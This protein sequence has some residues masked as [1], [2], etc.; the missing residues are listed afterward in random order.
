M[1][2]EVLIKKVQ[3]FSSKNS[4]KDDIHGFGH[5]RRVYKT[6]IEIGRKKD[7]NMLVLKISA[8]LHD[9]GRINENKDMQ[10]LNHATISAKRAVDFLNS[11]KNDLTQ[12]E[13]NNIF[14][15][16]KAHSFSN[17][18]FPETLEARILS[19]ADKIDALGAIGLYR[20]IGFTIKN[21]GNIKD[22]QEH[23]ENKIM[24]LKNRIFLDISKKIAEKKEKIIFNFY[25][26]IKKYQ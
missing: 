14:H 23:L 6:C 2:N 15:S 3:E 24:L 22:V 10:T 4:S 13:L 20:T 1:K 21:N 9:I 5:V 11:L 25:N 12:S 8:L 18:I 19:D 7:A 26:E 16:I 17:N